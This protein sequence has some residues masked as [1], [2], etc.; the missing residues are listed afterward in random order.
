M[1]SWGTSWGTS[2]LT[3]WGAQASPPIVLTPPLTIVLNSGEKYVSLVDSV[4]TV[5]LDSDERYIRLED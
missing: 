2:W 5:N 4:R 1:A 3:S